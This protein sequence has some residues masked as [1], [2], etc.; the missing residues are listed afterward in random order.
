L[1]SDAGEA[2][3]VES[4]DAQIDVRVDGNGASTI[5]L[6]AGFPLA[7]E[8][9]DAVAERLAEEYRVVRPDLRGMGASSVAAG[10]YLMETLAGDVAA[11][12]DALGL[13][14]ATIV[15][16]SLGGYVALAFARIF[17]ERLERM[18]LVC[19]RVAAD[20]SEQ[21]RAREELA[22]RLDAAHDSQILADAYADRL[23]SQATKKNRADIV[24][25]VRAIVKRTDPRGAAAMLRG[26]AMRGA[27]DD[28]A[29]DIEFPVLVLAGGS[30][31]VVPLEES[32]A[33]AQLFPRATFE[34]AQRSGHLPMLEE[35]D[36][37]YSVLVSWLEKTSA[38]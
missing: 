33:M 14:R 4:L 11:V 29:P 17:S 15:G 19:S 8:I 27:S 37:T 13:D 38:T 35:P 12:F 25:T 18:A 3:R 36:T 32:R 5:V 21:R 6:L 30:D 22:N 26:M 16:H 20:T 9:W 31:G 34:A 28:V 24:E 10:P 7:R 23:L 1:V 2:V